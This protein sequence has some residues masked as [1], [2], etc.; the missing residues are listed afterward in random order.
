MST[1]CVNSAISAEAGAEAEQRGDDRQ[2]HRDQRAEG[3]QQHHDRRHQ[4]HRG[5]EAE[6]RLLGGLDRLPAE[7][8]LETRLPRGL[9]DF[10][11]PFGGAHGQQVGFLVEHNRRERDLAIGGDR[12]AGRRPRV[13]AD[14]RGDVR[15]LGDFGEHRAHVRAH[16][17]VQHAA[18]GDAEDDLVAVA[19]LRREAVLQQVRGALRVGVGQR[20]VVG[21]FR[22]RRGRE[23]AHGDD[24]RDPA[25]YDEAAVG[26]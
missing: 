1:T 16:R 24:H 13:G 6:A 7:L 20:E 4:P 9:G 21:V 2:P 25:D 17:G 10:D 14:H 15:Q 11:D 19:R 5:G 8:H 18:V 26:G 22:P 3:D 12:L 23:G